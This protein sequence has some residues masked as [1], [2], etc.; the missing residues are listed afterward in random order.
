MS[1]QLAHA[2]SIVCAVQ[3]YTHVSLCITKHHYASLCITMHHYASLCIPL[4]S[5]PITDR[6]LDSVQEF[7]TA[8]TELGTV[9]EVH[10]LHGVS[11][12]LCLAHMPTHAYIAV[13]EHA[14]TCL[15]EIVSFSPG[16][17]S[18]ACWYLTVMIGFLYSSASESY[19]RGA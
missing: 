14:C 16:S 6:H 12:T 13:C 1:M 11:I 9:S 3:G 15:L 7:S 4:R 18:S 19:R 2:A 10:P 8:I 5:T 17:I